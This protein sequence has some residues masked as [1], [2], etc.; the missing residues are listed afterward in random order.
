M[1]S[2]LF[3]FE[4][5]G[6]QCHLQEP[7]SC[8]FN[9]DCFTTS[10][11]DHTQPHLLSIQPNPISN[12]FSL[13]INPS[14]TGSSLNISLLDINGRRLQ[15]WNQQAIQASTSFFLKDHIA[16]GFYLLS[17][18]TEEGVWTYKVLVE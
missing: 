18:Q 15:E 5:M 3:V 1:Q 11:I 2:G 10:T 6:D 9:T 8:T 13:S 14:L 16:A 4:G 12:E 7:P 17:L